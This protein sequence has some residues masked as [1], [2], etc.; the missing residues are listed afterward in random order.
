MESDMQWP[1][2][3][4]LYQ[5][6]RLNDE[7]KILHLFCLATKHDLILADMELTE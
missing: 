6:S 4:P 3:R 5:H 2:Y 7:E 1:G